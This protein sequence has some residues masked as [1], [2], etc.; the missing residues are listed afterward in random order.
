M[1]TKI[2]IDKNK[3]MNAFEFVTKARAQHDS[4][5]MLTTV[6]L[7]FKGDH[8]SLVCADG[9][10]IH[11]ASLPL[12]KR[13]EYETTLTRDPI[14]LPWDE[15]KKFSPVKSGGN[16]TLT[17]TDDHGVEVT[18]FFRGKIRTCTVSG[19]NARFPDY[20]A[21][22]PRFVRRTPTK[23]TFEDQI[24]AQ[25]VNAMT[26]GWFILT[27][28][29]KLLIA[30]DNTLVLGTATTDGEHTTICNA[31]TW[32]YIQ[33]AMTPAA[34]AYFH[35][36]DQ[37]T[38]PILVT[39]DNPDYWALV[40]PCAVSDYRPM[41]TAKIMIDMAMSIFPR[42]NMAASYVDLKLHD[43]LDQDIRVK[44]AR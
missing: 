31:V 7:E 22:K 34:T 36:D 42:A 14:L 16:I 20:E 35:I 39:Y 38:Q 11:A 13:P 2:S 12:L 40:M 26:W 6:L 25:A 41:D 29:N 18:Q 44:K 37:K 33:D 32:A 24:V 23:I 43:A 15:L 8:I 21:I 4:R 19:M 9:Y 17:I 1:A 30:R 3:W 28:D 5:P 27:P 10:R